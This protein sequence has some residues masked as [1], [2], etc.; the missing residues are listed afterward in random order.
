MIAW[1]KTK[2]RD[3]APSIPSLRKFLSDETVWMLTL[4]QIE[5][6]TGSIINKNYLPAKEASVSSLTFDEGNVLYSK[7][8]PYLNKVFLPNESGFATTELVPLRPNRKL[9][10]RK[11]LYYFLRSA[12]FLAFAT[13][14]V[15]GIKMPRVIMEKFWEY[16][17]PLPSLAEQR[18]IIE[19]LD[20]ADT[21]RK[22]RAEADK[23]GEK[24]L[25]V[26]FYKMFGDPIT[27]PNHWIKEPI[28][29]LSIDGAQY[30]A[31]ARA[32]EFTDGSPRY[33]RITDINDSGNLSKDDIK[34]LDSDDWQSYKLEWGDILFARSGA[35][36]GKTYMYKETDGLCAYAGY[37]IR[38]RLD[39]RRVNP[40]FLF[41]ATRTPYYR[42]WVNSKKRV[43]AQPNINGQE[44]GS[45]S[46]ALPPITLQDQFAQS[47]QQVD[48]IV[49]ATTNT[50]KKLNQL[51][52]LLLY[53]AF[54]GDLTTNWR[55]AHMKEILQE[56][57]E[58]ARELN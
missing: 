1:A 10:D 7:L 23:M 53:S 4:D 25:P 58:Q 57:E 40:W 18:R 11:F 48:A 54:S 55:E 52:E 41:S 8:R 37:L 28:G 31:N 14:N 30:G 3:V 46:I 5:S 38:F 19:I 12:P 27:N 13:Q 39:R 42:N 43:A 21:L 16:P 9:L 29:S 44:Y 22:K 56:I 15:A 33:V 6:G 49:N 35:T 47:A 24:I 45:F 26:L 51:F 17:I 50:K 36:V 32:V 20:Q 34:T 2:L